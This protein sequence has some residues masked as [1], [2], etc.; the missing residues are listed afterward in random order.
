M[1]LGGEMRD[2]HSLKSSKHPQSNQSRSGRPSII[3][4]IVGIPISLSSDPQPTGRTGEY[5]T[6]HTKRMRA[7]RFRG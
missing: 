7:I 4:L 1:I 3:L 5:I 6:V 2:W